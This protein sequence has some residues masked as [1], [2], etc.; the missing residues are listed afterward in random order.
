MNQ[1]H[2]LKNNS[3]T[4]AI[5]LTLLMGAIGFAVSEYVLSEIKVKIRADVAQLLQ[6]T[7]QAAT[8]RLRSWEEDRASDVMATAQSPLLLNLSRQLLNAPHTQLRNHPALLQLRH[9][10]KPILDTHGYQGFFIIAP[11]HTSIASMRDENLGS[12]NLLFTQRGLLERVFQ[13]D[14]LISHPM[15]SDIQPSSESNTSEDHTMF[16]ATPLRDRHQT[17]I[18]ALAFRLDPEASLTP[19]LDAAR[20]GNT[21]ESYLFNRDGLMLTHSRFK[22][23]L[24]KMGMLK[25][26]ERGSLH[27]ELRN[28]GGDMTTGFEPRWPRHQQPF[29][30]MM[31]MASQ[32]RDGMD[33]DGYADY[34][35]RKVVGIWHWNQVLNAGIATEMDSSEAYDTYAITQRLLYKGI[36][37]LLFTGFV[38]AFGLHRKERRIHE[39]ILDMARF[40]AENP[41]AIMR[42]TTEGKLIY[43]NPSAAHLLTAWQYKLG[44]TLSK[45]H[46]QLLCPDQDQHSHQ[47]HIADRWYMVASNPSSARDDINIYCM[48]V[49]FHHQAQL[50]IQHLAAVVEQLEEGVLITDPKANIKYVNPTWESYSGY[51]ADEVLGKKPSLLQSGHHDA[52][53]YALMWRRIHSG[54]PWFGNFINRH[55]DGHEYEVEQ[56]ITPLCDDAGET[57]GYISVS[58][59]VTDRNK[60]RQQME[61]TQRLESLGVLAGGIAHDFNNILTAIIGNASLARKRLP[62]NSPAIKYIPRIEDAGQRAADLCQQM[63]A[64]S[65]KGHF[66]IQPLDIS[67]LVESM[68]N[69]MQVSIS[70]NVILKYHLTEGLPLIQA[71][72]AQMQQIVLNLITN[73]NEAIEGKSG[74]ITFSTGIMQAD[75]DY[76]DVNLTGETLPEGRYVWMEVSD[77]GCGMDEKTL[78]KMFDPFFTTKTTGRGLGMS[79]IIGIVRGHQA[80]MKVYSEK[81]H[82]TTFKVLFPTHNEG[83]EPLPDATVGA[84]QPQGHGTVLVVDDEET[85]R[86]VAAIMLEEMGY[87]VITAIDGVEAVELYRTHQD[88]ITLVITDMT[89]PRMNGEECFRELRKLNPD[90]RV[91]LSSGYNEQDATSRFQGKGLV[92]FIQKPYGQEQLEA[93][94]HQAVN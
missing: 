30:R 26:Q 58:R 10:L 15:I 42:I 83:V 80:A 90:V 91:M 32:G 84:A 8:D 92:G 94:V 37:F 74:I 61:H 55:K 53:Y 59:D 73:A 12:E 63:L 56:T 70:K 85:I 54:K 31:T 21:G 5:A 11:D 2:P 52:S 34:R 47:I 79:A 1:L 45:S 66:I 38:I 46:L 14:T 75:S 76:L 44:D 22:A 82:G 50:K 4:I 49:T 72:A 67:A 57:I 60:K 16:V 48:D 77:T 27:I 25:P 23:Q 28:P 33:L 7:H 13:G 62:E 43:A 41:Q 35:G 19:I 81:G 6:Q 9:E 17:I 69:L 64:Y 20:L 86:E 36:I 39:K 24:Q 29:T 88:E 18:A 3:A 40:P 89:M 71:D 87:Q 93:V 51:R 68:I 78:N 65:G